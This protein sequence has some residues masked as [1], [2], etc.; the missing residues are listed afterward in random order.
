MSMLLGA[1]P[2]TQEKAF[3]NC[4]SMMPTVITMAKAGLRNFQSLPNGDFA[5]YY[6]DYFGLDGKKAVWTLRDIEMKNV[7]IDLN[8]DAL[9][10]HAYV[11]GSSSPFAAGGDMG[12]LGWI[13]SQGFA[14]VENEFLFKWMTKIAPNVAGEAFTSGTDIMRRFGVRP[15]TQEMAM[16]QHGPMEFLCAVQLFMEKWAQQYSTQID[17]TFMPELYPGQRILLDG[18]NLQ[19]YVSQVTH[20]CDFENGF[21]TTATICAPSNPDVGAMIGNI[22]NLAQQNNF[23]LAAVLSQ[24]S[25]VLF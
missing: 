16:I 15:L 12:I 8:D 18:H 20:N 1:S 2:G 24:A 19:V 13:Q 3:I 17:I 25:T 6:P 22:V 9:C 4:Q 5:A 10:T 7:Q 14:T 11:S 23:N 21:T